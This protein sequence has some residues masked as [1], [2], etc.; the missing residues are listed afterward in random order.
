MVA[1]DGPRIPW[2]LRDVDA[3]VRSEPVELHRTLVDLIDDRLHAHH[4]IDRRS[5][6]DAADRVLT[7]AL[8]AVIEGRSR[9]VRDERTLWSILN[10]IEDL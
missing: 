7:P 3:R 8:R 9:R 5:T 4:G 6:P 10:D 2:T 1:H